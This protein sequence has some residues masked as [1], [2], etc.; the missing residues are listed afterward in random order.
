MCVQGACVHAYYTYIHMCIYTLHNYCIVGYVA[1]SLHNYMH[2]N[3]WLSTY[4][5][6]WVHVTVNL[7]SIFIIRYPLQ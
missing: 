4:I 3:V 2:G 1:I 7:L 5:R 6:T